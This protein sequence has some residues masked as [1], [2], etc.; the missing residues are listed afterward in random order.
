MVRVETVDLVSEGGWRQYHL[1][2][3]TLNVLITLH[4]VDTAT[5]AGLVALRLSMLGYDLLSDLLMQC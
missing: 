2:Q 4:T 3:D 1:K 5:S